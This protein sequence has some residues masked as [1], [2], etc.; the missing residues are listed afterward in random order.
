MMSTP[1]DEPVQITREIF[2]PGFG[3]DVQRFEPVLD[4]L[5]EHAPPPVSSAA[6]AKFWLAVVDAFREAEDKLMLEGI[7]KKRINEH[8]VSL[9]ALI[10]DGEMILRTVRE[11]GMAQ[12]GFSID[13]LQAT[14][15][16]LHNTFRREHGPRNS[17]RTN[18]AI[19]KLFDVSER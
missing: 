5:E 3:A 4:W 17:A 8:R 16:S 15:D 2:P 1:Q 6:R 13:D 14:L 12:T 7:H 19:S 10:A 9:S 11:I 18:E